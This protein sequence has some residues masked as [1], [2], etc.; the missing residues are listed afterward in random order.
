MFKG[1]FIKI[2]K[3]F[4]IICLGLSSTSTLTKSQ[5]NNNLIT[6]NTNTQDMIREYIKEEKEDNISTNNIIV[7][8]EKIEEKKINNEVTSNTTIIEEKVETVN[9]ETT[10]KDSIKIN[11]I[12]DNVL[13]K[14]TTG[15]GFYLNHNINGVYDGIG[16][17][18]IDFRT[19]FKTRKTLIYAHS[20]KN[21][22]GPFN[23]LQRYHNDP[24]FQKKYPYIN[25]YYDNKHYTY[26]IF[27]VYV[28]TANS[29]QDEGLKYFHKMNYSNIEWEEEIQKYKN[30]SEYDTGVLV[31][32]KDK[33]LI[34]QT[35]S[36]DNNYYEKYY[37]FNLLIM[38][39]LI[40][41]D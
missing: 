10:N 40:K 1:V 17:P 20:N 22:S 36:M 39:K 29:E 37:R 18:Y 16:V 38:A 14:D 9:E 3:F 28:S 19:N 26:E 24:N 11:G 4:L 12:L 31:N 32:S 34:L 35:C 41:V 6:Y 13:L 8:N 27:S 15:E 23:I 25:I 2:F 30:N 7:E 21:G 33:I 5:I